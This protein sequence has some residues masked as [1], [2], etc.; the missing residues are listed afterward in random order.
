MNLFATLYL[1]EDV[2]PLIA[3]LLR[4]RSFN[5]V[6]AR[7]EQMLSEPDPVQLAYATSLERCIL[8]HNR[9]DYEMLHREYIS[10]GRFHWGIIIAARR[11]PHQVSDRVARLL[12]TLTADEIANQLFYV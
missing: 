12:D 8:T 11:G 6:T 1:D 4:N 2:A 3:I 7:D 10:S 5:A 9:G